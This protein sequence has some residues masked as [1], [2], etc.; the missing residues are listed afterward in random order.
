MTQIFL[1]YPPEHIKN[2][3]I[4]HSKPAGNPKTKITFIDGTLQEYDWS[5]DINQ[6]TMIDA[7]LFN[8]SEYNWAKEPKTVEIGTNVTSIGNAAF[9]GCS[10]LTSVTIPSSVTSIGDGAFEGCSG[11]TSVTIPSGVTS[12]ESSAFSGCRGLT[13]VTIPSS[14]TSIGEYAF[15]WCRGLTSVTI[16]DS[17]TIIK[18][19]AFN[20]CI[21]LTSVTFSGKDKAMVQDMANYNWGLK[22]GC[23]IHCMDGDITI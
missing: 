13:S 4:E 20:Y 11:L 17:V 15:S 7:G 22:K 5:G 12:I 8:G 16:P 2:W 23:V 6:Q 10:G 18:N 21:S 1:G 19:S 3:I 14:V 9:S